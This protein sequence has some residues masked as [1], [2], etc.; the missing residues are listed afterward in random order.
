[1]QNTGEAGAEEESGQEEI[2][3]ATG[4]KGTGTRPAKSFASWPSHE[5]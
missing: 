1:M 3:V 5:S 4:S 2:S